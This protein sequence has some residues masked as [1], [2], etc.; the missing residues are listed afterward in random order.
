MGVVS[1]DPQGKTGRESFMFKIKSICIIICSICN[2][3]AQSE[4][5]SKH[6]FT[7][8]IKAQGWCMRGRENVCP[9]C[10]FSPRRFMPPVSVPKLEQC[11]KCPHEFDQS[12][13]GIYGC[14]NC[15]G[16]GLDYESEYKRYV[17]GK[18]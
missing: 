9:S 12:L 2:K 10:K 8:W 7:R 18:N 1:A 11:P 5:T 14:P 3:D 4:T 6:D 17:E 13:L 15:H 16:E